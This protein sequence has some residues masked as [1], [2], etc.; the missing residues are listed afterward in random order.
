MGRCEARVTDDRSSSSRRSRL[1]QRRGHK[2]SKFGRFLGMSALGTFIPGTGLIAAGR[3]WLGGFVLA[4]FLLSV[5]MVV[6]AVA[7]LSVDRL[8]SYIGGDRQIQLAVVGALVAAAA[9]WLLIALVTHRALEPDGLSAGQRLVGALVVTVCASLVVAPMAL[10]ARMVLTQREV[11]GSLAGG[12]SLTTPDVD[13]A[14]PWADIPRLNVLLLGGDD[15]VG[16]E[17]V[18]PDTQM[19]ASIDTHSGATTVI[20]LPRNLQQ[21]PFPEDSPLAEIYPDGWVGASG[22]LERVLFAV[23][24]NIPRDHPDVFAGSSD[25]GADANKWAVEGALGIEI[26]YYMRV[27]LASFE[28][29]VDALGGITLDVPRDIP[30]GNKQ[31]PNTKECTPARGY[32]YAGKNQHLDGK[33]A[34]WFARSRCGADDYDRMARQQCVIDAI[35]SQV[36]VSTLLR[37]YQSLATV[38]KDNIVTDVPEDMFQPL[39]DLLLDVQ[40]QPIESLELNAKFFDALAPGMKSDDP[41]YDLIHAKIDDVLATTP[42]DAVDEPEA[43]TDNATSGTE[44]DGAVETPDAADSDSGADDGTPEPDETPDEPH[45]ASTACTVSSEDAD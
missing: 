14:D 7:M 18:R 21:M 2:R 34:L 30:I 44:P 40:G 37:T 36:N 29:I 11:I 20:S 33:E 1:E 32:I 25:P 9:I 16:R 38:A 6:F 8:A 41:D 26:H 5:G 4:L 43:P 31:I 42:E 24:K 15:G 39:L 3:R 19:V 10:G 35:V 23:Y 45:D 12:D 22:D 28:G 27:N 17:G 13:T